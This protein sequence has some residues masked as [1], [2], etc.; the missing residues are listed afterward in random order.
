MKIII[1]CSLKLKPGVLIKSIY[2]KYHLKCARY[3][4]NDI[5][6][7]YYSV[8]IIGTK[9]KTRSTPTLIMWSFIDYQID[10]RIFNRLN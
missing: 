7:I 9:I 3:S 6:C 10:Y 2:A 4:S 8:F 5:T 1:D